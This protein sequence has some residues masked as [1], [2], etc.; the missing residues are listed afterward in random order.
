MLYYFVMTTDQGITKILAISETQAIVKVCDSKN[1]FF[2]GAAESHHYHHNQLPANGKVHK[3]E[4][5]T[6]NEL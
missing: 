2:V 1:H 3:K 5:A 4:E 6:L